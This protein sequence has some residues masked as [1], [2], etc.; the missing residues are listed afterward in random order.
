LLRRA[1]N[2]EIEPDSRNKRQTALGTARS[3]AVEPVDEAKE[4]LSSAAFMP[5]ATPLR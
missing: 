3:T 4:T 5:I 1:T 2:V